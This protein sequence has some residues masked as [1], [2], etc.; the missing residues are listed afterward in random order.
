MLAGEADGMGLRHWDTELSA[1][2]L[3]P[4]QPGMLMSCLPVWSIAPYTACLPVW[5]Q[6]TCSWTDSL[7]FIS[8]G[9][10]TSKTG[11]EWLPCLSARVSVRGGTGGT[12][13]ARVH[14]SPASHHCLR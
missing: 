3:L 9:F 1:F 5:S 8:P 13:K 7:N 14:G 4:L 10:H 2:V 6:A 11:V 12:R